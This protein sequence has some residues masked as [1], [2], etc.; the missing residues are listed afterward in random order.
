MA[1]FGL[2]G[3]QVVQPC[4]ESF[5]EEEFVPNCKGLWSQCVGVHIF[6][7][8]GKQQ[9]TSVHK[10]LWYRALELITLTAGKMLFWFVRLAR[11]VRD[12]PS[13]FDAVGKEYLLI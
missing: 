5:K 4:L 3:S 6:V 12:G 1:S 10:A 9:L 13:G 11:L 7:Y 8:A 2:D